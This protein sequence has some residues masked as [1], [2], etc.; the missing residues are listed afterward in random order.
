[1]LGGGKLVHMRDC[2]FHPEVLEQAWG[3][4]HPPAA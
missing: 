1:M 3:R 2:I 4:A